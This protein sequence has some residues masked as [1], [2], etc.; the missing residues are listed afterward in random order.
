MAKAQEKKYRIDFV[1]VH[2]YWHPDP[3]DFMGKMRAI[4]KLYNLPIWITEFA[5]ADWDANTEKA[6]RFSADQVASFLE[7]VLPF[8]NKTPWIERFAWYPSSEK[9]HALGPSALFDQDGNLT[10]VGKVYAAG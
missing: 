1:C 9:S 4:H 5:I 3:N 2:W 6:N 8:L 10:K 7:K